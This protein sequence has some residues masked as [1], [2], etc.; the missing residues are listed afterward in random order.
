M[1]QPD[2]A[3]ETIIP[4]LIQDELSVVSESRVDLT[5]PV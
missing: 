3:K 1:R 5:V 2:I 4:F